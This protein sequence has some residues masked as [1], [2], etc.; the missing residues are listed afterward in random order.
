MISKTFYNFNFAEKTKANFENQI[1][2][3]K[4]KAVVILTLIALLHLEVDLVHLAVLT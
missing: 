4:T 3:L 1:G 2:I